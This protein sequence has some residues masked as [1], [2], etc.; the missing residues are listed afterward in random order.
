[1]LSASQPHERVSELPGAKTCCVQLVATNKLQKGD[2]IPAAQLAGIMAAKQ[3]ASL[4]PLCH[5]LPLSQV[6]L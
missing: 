4:I 6:A 3:T 1:M 5:S 2:V